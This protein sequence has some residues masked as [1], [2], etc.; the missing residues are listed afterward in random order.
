[1]VVTS[2]PYGDSR[3]TVAYGEFSSWAN[4]WL[5]FCGSESGTMLDKALMG[6]KTQKEEHF[7][8]ES[9][10]ESL[11]E[12][13]AAD[14]KRYY[15]VISFLNDYAKSI[16]SVA[17]MV[18]RNGVACYVVGNRTVKGV[19]IPLDYFTVGIFE[20]NGFEHVNTIVREFPT[21]RMPSKNSPSNVSGEKGNTMSNEYIVIMKKK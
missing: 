4:H 14:T 21:K 12:I 20:Q 5:G 10:K 18:N 6:G 15:E 2:P 9:V 3:T 13:K 17:E 1:M 7:V 16:K 19:Q 8:S 11:D